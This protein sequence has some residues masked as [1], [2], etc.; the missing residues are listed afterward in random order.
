MKAFVLKK[1]LDPKKIHFKEGKMCYAYHGS[2]DI[3]VHEVHLPTH[4]AELETF[5]LGAK[6]VISNF[7][8]LYVGDI[9]FLATL[10]GMEGAEGSRCLQCNRTAAN[11][12]EH[13]CEHDI[14]TLG[15]LEHA[16]K[17]T[18]E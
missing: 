3:S 4:L 12:G 7:Y 11:F 9:A 13:V 16:P 18:T 10:L 14:K 5:Q 1:D 15:F 17:V 2:D 6:K 8:D